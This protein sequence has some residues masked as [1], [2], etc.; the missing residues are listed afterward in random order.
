MIGRPAEL[1]HRGE[2]LT[3]DELAA[4]DSERRPKKTVVDEGK[5]ISAT[6]SQAA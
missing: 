4:E 1:A 2:A 6:Q 3:S 5:V